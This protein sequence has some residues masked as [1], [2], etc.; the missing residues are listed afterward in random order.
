MGSVS[1]R[2]FCTHSHALTRAR[3]GEKRTHAPTSACSET[4]WTCAKYYV[5]LRQYCLLPLKHI[6][7]SIVARIDIVIS[8]CVQI[9]PKNNLK[10]MFV[11]TPRLH[12]AFSFFSCRLFSV[13]S[14][15]KFIGRCAAM[16]PQ[17]RKQIKIAQQFV[18]TMRKRNGE[19]DNKN[20]KRKQTNIRQDAGW[21][22]D[23]LDVH[24]NR[25]MYEKIITKFIGVELATTRIRILSSESIYCEDWIVCITNLHSCHLSLSL[26]LA[27]THTHMPA[28]GRSV[29][30]RCI[31]TH[32]SAVCTYT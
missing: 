31:S 19:N 9:P 4:L 1:S 24:D 30:R 23:G 27:H 22:T 32:R 8:V 14:F 17:N 7:L 11:G 2:L 12:F 20:R 18:Q 25:V 29:D 21:L 6:T 16:V 5:R 15:V 3:T 10:V 26:A 13:L 28:D